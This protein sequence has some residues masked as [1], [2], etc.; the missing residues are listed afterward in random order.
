[1]MKMMINS[2]LTAVFV[3]SMVFL[4]SCSSS[5]EGN[6]DGDLQLVWEDDFSG[7]IGQLPDTSVWNFDIGTGWG[8]NQLEFDTDRPTNASLD[9]QGNLL[10]IAREESFQ[11]SNYTSARITTANKF[12]KKFGRIEARIQLPWGQGIWPAFWLLG[13]NFGSVGW[14]QCGE[15]DI[16]EYRGQEPSIVHATVHGPGYS[17]GGGVTRSYTLPNSRFDTGFHIFA[18]EWNENSID[19]YVDDKLYHRVTPDDVNGAWVFNQPFFII[20]NVAVGGGY[21]GPPD[22]TTVFPQTMVIDYVRVYDKSS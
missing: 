6:G 15:I 13:E 22:A 7:P 20:L 17:A 5:S 19:W 4:A 21:V 11:G 14:P 1:M 18:I 12:T 9:G 16:M 8:N 2:A 10:I 3:L